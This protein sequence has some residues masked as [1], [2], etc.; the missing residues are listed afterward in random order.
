MVAISD[1]DTFTLLQHNERSI[2]VRVAHI[3]CPERRQP[4][5]AKA[6]TFTS[7]AI[8]NKRVRLK[9]LKQDRYGRYVAEVFYDG[10]KNLSQNSKS[11]SGLAL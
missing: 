10:K 2:K 5:S 11:R 9:V 4:F 8:F 1:G 6:K 7:A 3:D